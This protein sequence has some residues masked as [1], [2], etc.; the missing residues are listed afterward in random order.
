MPL[1]YHYLQA[2]LC[3]DGYER[4]AKNLLSYFLFRYIANEEYDEKITTVVA[5]CVLSVQIIATLWR[6]F[7]KNEEDMIEIC[8]LYSQEI[9]YSTENV[10]D[11]LNSTGDNLSVL[12]GNECDNLV[13]KE[14]EN[15]KQDLYGYKL[16]NG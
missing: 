2:P 12:F 1:E 7:A 4:E 13:L 15:M 6:N 14:E 9:E 5:F 16:K 10:Y 3:I 8:R 11:L